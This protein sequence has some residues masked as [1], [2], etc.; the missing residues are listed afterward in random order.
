MN[1]NASQLHMMEDNLRSLAN[2][3]PDVPARE[4][5]ICRLIVHIGRELSVMCEQTLRPFGLIEAEFRVLSTIYTQPEGA[6]HPGELCV[7]ASQSPANMSRISDALVKRG[8]I[9]RVLSAADRRK[10]VLSI[11][12]RGESLVRDLLPKFWAPLQHLLKNVPATDQQQ[13]VELLK[14]LEVA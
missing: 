13:L 12:P 4:L 5:L 6:A 3:M 7:R 14:C 2:L 10:M 11:T 8:L 9:T 1:S